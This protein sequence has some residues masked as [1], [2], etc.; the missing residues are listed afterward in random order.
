MI[1]SRDARPDKSYLPTERR[2][3]LLEEGASVCGVFLILSLS[4][5]ATCRIGHYGYL[6]SLLVEAAAEGLRFVSS[7]GSQHR[8]AKSVA[9]LISK[10]LSDRSKL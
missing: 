9:R 8:R 2:Y 1:S 7:I 3:S 4:S 10:K 6:R 5:A